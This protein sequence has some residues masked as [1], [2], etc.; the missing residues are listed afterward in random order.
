M[1]RC[2]IVGCGGC[3][4]VC[5]RLGARPPVVRIIP[6]R[7]TNKPCEVDLCVAGGCLGWVWLVSKIGQL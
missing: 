4:G 7:N 2:A 5:E 3:F 1:F 6:P